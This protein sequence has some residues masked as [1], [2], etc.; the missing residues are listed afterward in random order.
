MSKIIELHKNNTYPKSK[1]LNRIQ[2]EDAQEDL[3]E[4][5]RKNKRIEKW[6]NLLFGTTYLVILLFLLFA[7]GIIKL[8]QNVSYFLG[9]GG[10][11]SIIGAV[12]RFVKR[13]NSS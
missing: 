4:K 5:K 7:L 10:L 6:D 13:Q 11:T 1:A 3:D 2:E 12:F 9:A 8:P